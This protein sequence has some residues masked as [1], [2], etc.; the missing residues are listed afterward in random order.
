MKFHSFKWW[1][2]ISINLLML[3][4]LTITGG[5]AY[6]SALDELDEVYDAQLAHTARM[7]V[8]L[9]NH[10]L[11][12]NGKI[13]IEIPVPHLTDVGEELS[14]KQQRQYA[15][16]KYENKIAFQIWRDSTLLMHSQN[17]NHFQLSKPENGYHEIH[18]DDHLWITYSLYDPVKKVW[19][20]TAQREDVRQEL[21]EHLA[22]AEIRPLAFM[23]LPLSV[24]IYVLIT[25]TLRPIHR[26]SHQLTTRQATDLSPIQIR[27]PHELTPIR[28]AINQLLGRINAYLDKEKRFIADAS[29]ELRTPLAVMQIHAENLAA[30]DGDRQQQRALDAIKTGCKNMAHLVDQLL[31]MAKLEGTAPIALQVT[32]LKDLIESSLSQLPVELLE[33]MQW[34]VSVSGEVMVDPVLMQVALRNLLENAAKYSLD[35]SEIAIHSDDSEELGKV[36]TIRNQMT[37]A[38]EIEHI[39]ERF[40]RDRQSQQIAGSGLGLSI[41][42]LIINLHGIAISYSKDEQWFDVQIHF[43]P[44][45]ET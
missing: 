13:P 19:V 32:N 20:Y 37:H 9:N 17:A 36:L 28:Q 18:H 14:A 25:L 7:L 23:L 16:H 35:D 44:I 31:A 40:Y 26:L 30:S 34:S 6:L 3:V 12:E 33:R 39:E 11:L 45:Q 24:L 27:L 1:L 10:A 21:S 8:I 5:M 38:P 15:V 41:V 42:R 2:L 29:H 43:T 22:E 4:T